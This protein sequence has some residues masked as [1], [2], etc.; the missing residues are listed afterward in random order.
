M[1]AY[2][3]L[4]RYPSAFRSLTG[5]TRNEFDN[6]LVAFRAA[7]GRQQRDSQ[8]TRR[9][10]PRRRAAGAGHPHRHDDCHRLLLALVWLRVYP[11]YELLGFFFGLHKR[12]AQLNVRAVLAALDTID[13]FPFDRPGRARKKLR[14]ADEVMAAFPQVRVLIDSK[15]Q[16]VNRPTGSDAQKPYYSGKKKAHTVKI[17][18]VVD[19]CGRIEAVGASVP[20]GANHDLP[21]LCG[22]G[23]L[24]QLAEGEAAMVD[25]GYVG[26]KNYYPDVPI[27]IPFK[28][29]RNHP[30]T[31]EQK[32]YNREVA[33]YRIVVEHTMAQLNRFTV[34]R[35]VF[36]GQQRGRHSQVARVV[37]KLVNRRLSVKPLKTYAA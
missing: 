29:G 3:T 37:A 28:A 27:V 6:L 10:Q 23:I 22:S 1:F 20:G 26:V 17:Q 18:V 13:D 7:Q 9:G 16:R 8:T 24:E 2:D 33:R 36:R 32:A 14:S 19:P 30:L 35:Q 21:L 4:I 34:L 31:E 11:T 15:E 5:M 25:K 12:N